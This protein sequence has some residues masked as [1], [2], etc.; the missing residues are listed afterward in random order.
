MKYLTKYPRFFFYAS[1]IVSL[2][3][4]SGAGKK[5]AIPH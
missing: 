5:W 2:V 1:V 3:V 4:A